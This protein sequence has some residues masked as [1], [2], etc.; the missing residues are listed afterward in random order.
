[1]T[2]DF[3]QF[4]EEAHEGGTNGHA[5]ASPAEA[6]VAEGKAKSD[7]FRWYVVH[8]YS[9]HENKVKQSIEKAVE[10]QGL[11]NLF[12]QVL[13]P[14][15]EVTEMKKG[16]KVKVNRKFFPSYI[17]VH[18]ELTEEMMHLVNNIPGVTRFVGT[19]NKPAPVTDK[20]V[21][22]ILKRGDTTTKEKE[23]RE[24]PFN[25]GEHVKVID[26]PFSDFNGV[27]DEI[28]PERGK[29]K[30]MVGIFGRETPVEL[31]FLQVERL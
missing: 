19:G 15:E 10:L 30:V 13:I 9:G 22:R 8:T 14:M 24:I 20:E 25:V 5:G 28:N 6:A 26:G 7:K 17:L 23:I 12:D 29:L 1:M 3:T 21:D 16:K 18:L 31:D 27:I 11:A 2:Q 4:G